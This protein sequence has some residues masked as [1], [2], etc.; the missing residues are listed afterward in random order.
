MTVTFIYSQKKKFKIPKCRVHKNSLVVLR[1]RS[2]HF[3]FWSL[4][5]YSRDL[6]IKAGIGGGVGIA[7]PCN[8]D[9]R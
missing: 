2:I 4:A 9:K 3:F 8:H 7:S 6:A 1:Y 5:T